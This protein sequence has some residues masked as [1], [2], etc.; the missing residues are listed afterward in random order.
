MTDELSLVFAALAD[1]TRRAILARLAAG[2]ATAGQHGHRIGAGQQKLAPVL[3]AIAQLDL[4]AKE[5]LIQ[6][7]NQS[8]GLAG[9]GA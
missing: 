1:P 8:L 6:V 3:A 2:D 9:H 5:I 7:S 4:V